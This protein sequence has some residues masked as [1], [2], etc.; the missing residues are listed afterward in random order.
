MDR[1]AAGRAS[2]TG[3][4]W[5]CSTAAARRCDAPLRASPR[6]DRRALAC[7]VLA[8]LVLGG[9]L[10]VR[11]VAVRA[12][13][14]GHQRRLPA[15]ADGRAGAGAT[16][17]QGRELLPADTTAV[18]DSRGAT[19]APPVVVL[20]RDGRVLDRVEATVDAR[21]HVIRAAIARTGRELGGVEVCLA[22]RAPAVL[23]RG[24]TPPPGSARHGRSGRSPAAR[25]RSPTRWRVE[26]RGGASRRPSR[27]A[28]RGEHASGGLWVVWTTSA[29]IAASLLL[30]GGFVLRTLV[31]GRPMPRARSG[32][33]GGRG[34][35]RRG[36]VAHHAG[37]P[38]ARRGCARRVRPVDR[39]DRRTADASAVADDLARAG[40]GDGRHGLRQASARLTY[41][42]A[43]W[44]PQ[45]QRRL[46][47]DL[48]RPLSR[49]Q[50]IPAGEAEPEPPLYY[51]L[52]AIPYRVAHAGTLLD[53]M[54]LMRLLLG[55]ARGVDGAALVPVRA[56]VPAGAAVGVDRRR[57]GRRVH[58]DARV[59]LR[60]GEPG[61]ARCSRSRRRCSS[62]SHGRGG[63]ASRCG[64]RC[65]SAR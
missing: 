46:A 1:A 38:G 42:A 11:A 25:S 22:L 54:L 33:R 63:A 60:R 13:S 12:A 28:S 47:A 36:V 20:R 4:R 21:G 59:R 10:A 8:A 19:A 62:A 2:D 5:L 58:A 31:L 27:D 34:A 7:C 57:P 39:R 37:V 48:A 53:R 29:L 50:T 32:D 44:S 30:T 41:R 40:D 52:E 15:G 35:Q 61:R 3:E 6:W 23:L 45:Q 64:W 51:A 26:A 49:R 24:P 43:A 17:C 18:R 16:A 14:L 55:A 65:A 56:R 9:G